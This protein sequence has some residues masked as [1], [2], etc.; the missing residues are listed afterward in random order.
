MDEPISLH[1]IFA[2]SS[3]VAR[4]RSGWEGAMP[5]ACAPRSSAI[6]GTVSTDDKSWEGS[7]GMSTVRVSLSLAVA[8]TALTAIGSNHIV[9][10]ASDEIDDAEA[11]RVYSVVLPIPFSSPEKAVDHFEILRETRSR[12]ACPL[13]D[14]LP[15]EWRSVVESYT[16]ENVRVRTLLPGFDVGL[17]YGLV[18]LAHVKDLLLRAGND[19][20]TL[21]GGW[22]EAYAEFPNGKLLAVSAVGFD[23]TKTRAMVVVQYNCGLSRDYQPFQ[24]DC[25]GGRS[26]LLERQQ[27][28]W[29]LAKGR[30]S[31]GWIS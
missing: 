9:A 29:M 5:G 17:P 20:K 15:Q 30:E 8:L 25:H 27:G 6:Q 12:N 26:V 7:Q 14:R 10:N 23:E 3:S 22:P 4:P 2:S 16:N 13:A 1:E 18:S 21:R 31:C 11:Y 19:G 28:G 24:H